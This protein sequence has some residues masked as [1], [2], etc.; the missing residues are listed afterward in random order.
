MKLELFIYNVFGFSYW[1]VMGNKFF[2]E[3]FWWIGFLILI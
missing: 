3:V 1:D 2:G